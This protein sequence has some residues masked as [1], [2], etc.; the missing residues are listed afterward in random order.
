[1]LL[2]SSACG[3]HR[4]SAANASEI[5]Q[6]I[7]IWHQCQCSSIV[8]AHSSKESDVVF[9]T[10]TNDAPQVEVHSSREYRAAADVFITNMYQ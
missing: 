5:R 3:M 10:K 8:V 9:D 6:D 2:D 1:M 4:S 7:V